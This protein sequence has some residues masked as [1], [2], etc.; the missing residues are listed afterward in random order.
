MVS[1]CRDCRQQTCSCQLKILVLFLNP[2]RSV[3]VVSLVFVLACTRLWGNA[4]PQFIDMNM[5][6]AFCIWKTENLSGPQTKNYVKGVADVIIIP[7]CRVHGSHL[8]KFR[9]GQ[10]L[11]NIPAVQSERHEQTKD[12]IHLCLYFTNNEKPTL[13][14]PF[15]PPYSFVETAASPRPHANAHR[16]APRC[17]V[18]SGWS[19]AFL[20]AF[21]NSARAIFV[22]GDSL[23]ISVTLSL[24]NQFRN[25]ML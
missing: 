22:W 2:L 1:Y 5:S 8:E 13:C 19:F 20:L 12:R 11:K 15:P 7:S 23:L 16:P 9:R 21:T 24:T 18:L 25:R 17:S 6:V 14:T 4:N 10:L 3:D